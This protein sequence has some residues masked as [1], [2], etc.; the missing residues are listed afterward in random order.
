MIHKFWFSFQDTNLMKRFHPVSEK[1]VSFP[2]EQCSNFLPKEK[3]R[4]DVGLPVSWCGVR[5]SKVHYFSTNPF[6]NGHHFSANIKE[7]II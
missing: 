5:G 2:V 3:V 1:S 7:L 4:K 6:I